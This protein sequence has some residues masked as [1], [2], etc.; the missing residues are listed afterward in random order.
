M[1]MDT[2]MMP[3]Y[4]QLTWL[5]RLA[6]ALVL[7]DPDILAYM[8]K[9]ERYQMVKDFL[10][11]VLVAIWQMVTWTVSLGSY[12]LP[13]ALVPALAVLITAMVV[14]LEISLTTRS[15]G[16]GSGAVAKR[17][18]IGLL[19]AMVNSV[20]FDLA[21]LKGE[22]TAYMEERRAEINKATAASYEE[23]LNTAKEEINTQAG[24]LQKARDDLL[25]FRQKIADDRLRLEGDIARLDQQAKDAAL[26]ASRQKD[27]LYGRKTGRGKLFDD[28]ML[29]HDQA[30]SSQALSQVTLAGLVETERANETKL[31]AA[32]EQ[33]A[34]VQS[35]VDSRTAEL[36]KERDAQVL[37]PWDGPIWRLKA[38]L[39]MKQDPERGMAV[40]VVMA[41][42]FLFVL[43]LDLLFLMV[44]TASRRS[45]YS[46]MWESRF[47]RAVTAYRVA[48]EDE[49]MWRAAHQCDDVRQEKQ[50]IFA[51]V[52][53]AMAPLS[54][55]SRF[56]DTKEAT[57]AK[58]KD[59]ARRSPS[60]AQ[61]IWQAYANSI[62]Q[63]Y[64][65]MMRPDGS[66]MPAE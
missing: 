60:Q 36:T 40:T 24:P 38:F 6:A 50:R 12:D 23:R 43:T 64:D 14:K 11:L 42:T 49:L 34:Q 37:P 26:E 45:L 52:Q 19:F 27:G 7:M 41:G 30:L 3:Q 18:A 4:Q 15:S 29:R 44:R 31:V 1:D 35:R 46:E 8:P 57:E 47:E 20:G 22:T 55:L 2:D 25:A 17:V 53:V 9:D 10:A 54:A 65:R 32:N 13:S 58:L 62:Q 33:L 61:G 51:G 16:S 56:V 48:R 21:L 66:V 39:A 59:A 28:A 63:A 5:E